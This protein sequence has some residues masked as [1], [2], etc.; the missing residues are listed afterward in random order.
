MVARRLVARRRQPRSATST[1]RSRR[2]SSSASRSSSRSSCSYLKEHHCRPSCPRRGCS[3][4]GMNEFRALRRVA[5][6]GRCSR[7][8]CISTRD[9]ALSTNA[10]AGAGRLRRVRQRSEQ[11]GA[12]RRLR[13]AGHE[14]RLHDRGPALRRDAPRRARLPDAAARRRPDRRRAGQGERSPSRPRGTDSDFVVKLI[15]VYPSD[16]PTPARQG[17]DGKPVPAVERRADGRLS[18][19]GARRAVPRRSSAT[20]SRSRSRS[21]TPAS[22][23]RSRSSC[24]TS[25]TRSA[26]ATG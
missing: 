17:R 3:L 10:R 11:A 16:Y 14:R 19:A 12:V 2:A 1:S 15:D 8:R 23:R 5:A 13:R 7:R 18:A 4:T 22:R 21:M 6:D 20:A 24:P 26:A 25:T 9:G